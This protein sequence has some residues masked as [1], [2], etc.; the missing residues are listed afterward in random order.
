MGCPVGN[1]DPLDCAL[2]VTALH[3]NLGDREGDMVG[4]SEGLQHTSGGLLEFLPIMCNG[5]QDRL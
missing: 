3:I 2:K 5:E 4:G 1:L